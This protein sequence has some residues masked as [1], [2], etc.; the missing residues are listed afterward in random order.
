MVTYS[1][2][3][4]KETFRYLSRHRWHIGNPPMTEATWHLCVFLRLVI[5]I[6]GVPHS[7]KAA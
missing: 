1:L 5:P 4:I 7:E 6:M 3:G 2:E